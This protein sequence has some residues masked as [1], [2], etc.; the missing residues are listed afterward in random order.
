MHTRNTGVVDTA[1]EVWSSYVIILMFFWRC[2]PKLQKY[3]SQIGSAP[4][5]VDTV[6]ACFVFV[7][8]QLPVC[9]SFRG[10][11]PLVYLPI[12]AFAVG[13]YIQLLLHPLYDPI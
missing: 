8:V 2:G 10:H 12:R 7:Y 9:L 1:C 5:P 13:I 3:H 4:P 6:S 11:T